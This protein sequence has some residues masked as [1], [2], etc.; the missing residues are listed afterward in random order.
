[1]RRFVLR[2][3]GVV[4]ALVILVVVSL[5]LWLPWMISGVGARYGLTVEA[6]DRIGYGRLELSGVEFR[7]EGIEVRADRV[8]LP[9]WPLW[10]LRS[11]EKRDAVADSPDLVVDGWVLSVSPTGEV[12]EK[13]DLSALG[14]YDQLV[15]LM[16]TL[17]RFIPRILLRN[18]EVR[19]GADLLRFS[20]IR[21]TTSA[22]KAVV[23][24]E[25][26]QWEAIARVGVPLDQ[27]WSADI[28]FNPW[29]ASASIV[30]SRATDSLDLS[31]G[32]QWEANALSG[33]VR[34]GPE[35]FLPESARIRSE[36]LSVDPGLAGIDGYRPASGKVDLFWTGREFAV[37]LDLKAD[38]V[39]DPSPGSPSL[40]VSIA[41]EGDF[42]HVRI[43]GI[44]IMVP[45]AVARLSEPIE[46][47]FGPSFLD[48][49]AR[50]SFEI[51]LGASPI[52]ASGWVGGEADVVTVKGGVPS[53]V[54]R[55]RAENVIVDGL[56]DL[57]AAS[58]EADLSLV[59]PRLMIDTAAFHVGA[60]TEISLI[61]AI[62]LESRSVDGRFNASV[63]AALIDQF[64]LDPV[65]LGALSVEGEV[66]GPW[67]APTFALLGFADR[68]AI[69]GLLPAAVGLVVNGCGLEVG[70]CIVHLE[71]ERAGAEIT[72][73]GGF[74]DGLP[75][76]RLD[77][78][79]LYRDG[80]ARIE[81]AVESWIE[82]DAEGK[83]GGQFILSG[84]GHELDI[85]F[86]LDWPDRARWSIS[87]KN[88]DTS[89]LDGLSDLDAGWIGIE[90]L[91]ST[92]EWLDGPARFSFETRGRLA[93]SDESV[94]FRA[95]LA[96][97]EDALVVN[98]LAVS[99]EDA[100]VLTIIGRIPLTLTPASVERVR[101]NWDAPVN[102]TARSAPNPA[103]WERLAAVTGFE[104]RDPDLDVALA[105]PM[106][107]PTGS[108]RVK[109]GSVELVG[110]SDTGVLPGI[111]DLNLSAR[112]MEE[113][114]VLD[115]SSIRVEGEK[116]QIQ[117]EIPLGID[118][119]RKLI[120]EGE[121][122]DYRDATLNLRAENAQ[123]RAFARFLPS[124]LGPSGTLD[125]DVTLLPGR[126]FDGYVTLEDAA[127]RPIRPFGTMQEIGARVE[128]RDRTIHC[129]QVSAVIGGQ[130]IG[131]SGEFSWDEEGRM[132]YDFTVKGS[133]VPFVREPGLVIR[134]DL[135]L[136]LAGSRNGDVLL[137]GDLRLMDSLFVADLNS[138][139]SGSVDSPSR[140]P[141]Y[142]SIDTEPFAAWQLDLKVAGPKFLRVETPVFKG[143]FSA[144]FAL[145]GTLEQ[146]KAL[147]DIR[148]DS[149]RVEFPFATLKLDSGTM[150]IREENPYDIA[151]DLVARSRVFGFDVTMLV[152]GWSSSPRLVFESEPNLGSDAVLLMLTTGEIPRRSGYYSMQQRMTKLAVY[153]G[154]SLLLEFGIGSGG[155]DRFVIESGADIS[156]KGRETY[157]V[158]LILTEDWSL[159]G[160]YDEFDSYNG[161]VKWKVFSR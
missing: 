99:T 132:E 73:S 130:K 137:S 27:P 78:L 90:V 102:F 29:D 158:E 20:E 4:I 49:S 32:L 124:V 147:G 52:P 111:S 100:D 123:V 112:I 129:R 41:A 1:M 104:I 136:R 40:A 26:G 11:D 80:V 106:S 13:S 101:I 79:V 86:D 69:P 56:E 3:A 114:L 25:G 121:M 88:L 110:E 134:S 60:D 103:F 131:V 119:W 55:F 94:V 24:D 82:L 37:D 118:R 125:M 74:L 107:A 50:F 58:A 6:H 109:A 105:G 76:A 48:Q 154:R 149:G 54:A 145:T 47:P 7:M 92:G 66:I 141:P 64:I 159:V 160:G 98:E 151:L 115:E 116:L 45:W 81:S 142:F 9:V 153:L 65:V 97:G 95:D 33:M 77:G 128:F 120:G 126:R 71:T 155:E 122:P 39:G 17:H 46:I 87:G 53:V 68:L 38:S 44:E 161:G 28:V 67:S 18:G 135:D 83:G 15:D 113:R 138:L 70:Q 139:L 108:I 14:I 23:S 42:D 62:D 8:S 133:K 51:D 144:E 143:V 61:G 57:E 36:T 63:G 43:G 157:S 12:S 93:Q 89:L 91:R 85:G 2:P 10:L 140:R 127:L 96:G 34:F 30:V 75:Y 59:F 84:E 31:L 117:G 146:P 35:G 19:T 150:S 22:F 152:E 16:P 72:G 156:L 21:W 148:V 5:P